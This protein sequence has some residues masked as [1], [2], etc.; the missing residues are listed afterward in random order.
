MADHLNR[1]A[2]EM[3]ISVGQSAELN[4]DLTLSATRSRTA[5][6]ARAWIHHRTNPLTAAVH[7]GH[8]AAGQLIA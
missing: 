2:G 8:P 1:A 6:I 4:D 7:S 5:V 3:L